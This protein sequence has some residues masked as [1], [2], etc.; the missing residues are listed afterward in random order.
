MESSSSG[1]HIAKDPE[2]LS[3]FLTDVTH[4]F[5]QDALIEQFIPGKE[6][7][8]SIIGNHSKVE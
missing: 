2:E 6:F 1:I 5:K 7:T 4:D 3:H 8:V